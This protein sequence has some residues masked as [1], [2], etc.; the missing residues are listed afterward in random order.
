MTS[1]SELIDRLA[2]RSAIVA[3]FGQ[4]YVGLQLAVHASR[5]GI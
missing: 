3:V 1:S 5:G 4:G 2:N